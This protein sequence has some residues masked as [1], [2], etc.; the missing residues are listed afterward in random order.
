MQE[1]MS[2]SACKHAARS[3][4]PV[5]WRTRRG[6]THSTTAAACTG[7]R[8]YFRLADRFVSFACLFLRYIACPTPECHN[9]KVQQADGD[10]WYCDK[11]HKLT[12]TPNYRYLLSMV[13]QDDTGSV[14]LSC[15]DREAERI[16][17]RPASDMQQ[18]KE[19]D[20]AGFEQTLKD[21]A[22]KDWNVGV[23][24]GLGDALLVAMRSLDWLAT[25][26]PA[27]ASSFANLCPT[28]R[29]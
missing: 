24:V 5:T 10:N 16:I 1:E 27:S 26:S 7:W 17:G 11:C 20:Q 15:F 12:S 6:E 28:R 18:M 22:N 13:L 29:W 3:S 19:Q 21:A 9:K 2:S 14:W 23:Q 4:S 25:C 8:Q